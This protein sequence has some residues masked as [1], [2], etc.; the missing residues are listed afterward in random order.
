MFYWLSD[1]II[2]LDELLVTNQSKLDLNVQLSV[3]QPF[4]LVTAAEE[5]VQSM[6]IVL[7]DGATTKIRVFFFFDSNVQDRYS[8]NYSGV[9]RLEYHEHPNQVNSSHS[10]VI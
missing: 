6:Q 1:T 3:K 9:L 5:H 10:K 2:C 4:H 7:I 8:R